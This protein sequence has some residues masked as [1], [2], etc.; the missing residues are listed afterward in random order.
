MSRLASWLEAVAEEAD[1]FRSNAFLLSSNLLDMTMPVDNNMMP[2]TKV[3]VELL[4]MHDLL[5]ELDVSRG[6]KSDSDE[7]K[8]TQVL[9][10]LANTHGGHGSNV[11]RSYYR[12]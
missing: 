6:R 10:T 9:N 5:L 1:A 3:S 7:T 11:F 4:S 2:G 12:G 8:R